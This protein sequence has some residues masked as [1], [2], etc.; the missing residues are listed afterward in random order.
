M[1]VNQVPCTKKVLQSEGGYTNHPRD[2]GGP[3]NFGITI[4][5]YRKYIDPRGT[6]LDVKRMKVE[7]AIK[8]YDGMY[9]DAQLC[10]ELPAGL[11]Y[12]V[13]DYGV[14]S[15]IGRPGR[16]LRALLRLPN[17]GNKPVNAEV[18]AMINRMDAAAQRRLIIR[19]MD[20]RLAFLKA[21][22]TWPV[23]GGG[24]GSRVAQVRRDAL[25]MFDRA[26]HQV[27]AS[28]KAYEV[29]EAV[30]PEEE[31]HPDAIPPQI[32][33]EPEP[34]TNKEVITTAG[35]TTGAATLSASDITD[36]ANKAVEAKGNADQL[37][38]TDVLAQLVHYP[39]FWIGVTAMVAIAGYVCYRMY[40]NRKG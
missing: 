34:L 23:F 4:H 12:A 8:I 24:W 37:G 7:Q 20:E 38:I 29:T 22:K 1:K 27:A 21:L 33:P 35:G 15:G 25:A 17:R 36:A 16:V 30:E 10:D 3:T 32:K 19:F 6:A 39:S 40:Q 13:F 28:A 26:Q 11:D 31:D 18:I 2:P 9:W 5:D 14:N